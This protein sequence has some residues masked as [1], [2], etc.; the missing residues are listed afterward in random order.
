M[1]PLLLAP[2]PIVLHVSPKGSDANSGDDAHPLASLA[3][4]R[5]RIRA[6]RKTYDSP[7]SIH[8]EFAPGDYQ[9]AGT[10]TLTPQ[11]S[12]TPDAPIVYRAA[13]STVT[14]SGGTR[15]PAWTPTTYN[16]HAAWSVI[17][18]SGPIAAD[19]AAVLSSLWINGSRRTWARYP[20]AGAFAK[21]ESIPEKP[22]G[23]WLV[24]PK[25]FQFSPA[26][27]PAW[28]TVF[29]GASVTTFT[30]WIDT[31]L[32]V[33]SIDAEK[34]L[35][36]F[37][38]PNMIS[39][40]PTNL[41]LIEGAPALLDEPGEWWCDTSSRTVYT[42]PLPGESRD[43]PTYVPRLST[44]INIQGNLD[45]HETVHD[46]TFEGLTFAHAQWW[47]S[48]AETKAAAA[49]GKTPG[50]MQAAVGVPGA[51][52]A[53]GAER[54]AFNRCT[55]THVDSYALELARACTD[56]TI[57]ACTITDLGAGAIKIGETTIRTGSD[58]TQRNTVRDCFL[59]DGGH[60]HHQ[61]VG[62]W[63]GQ[64]PNNTLTHNSITEFDYT[65]IS[66]G[67]TWGYG[68]SAAGCNIVEF[69]RVANLGRRPGNAEPPL[70]DM[71]GIYTLG[72]QQGT[73]IKSNLFQDIFGHTIA[74]GIYFDEG[75]TG[76]LAE[77]NTVK[78]T[79][80]GSFHQHYGKDNIVRNNWLENARDAQLWRTRREDHN[81]FT[82]DH[83]IV[84]G[85]SD[86][87]L[88]GDWTANYNTNHNLYWR[89]SGKP[90]V[91]PGNMNL[92]QWQST[93][94]DQGSQI[95]DP[96]KPESLSALGITKPDTSTAG[97]R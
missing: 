40:E 91:F 7:T 8:V 58:L 13:P 80:H 51:I 71:G 21:I 49:K 82:F 27:A 74:W 11:D 54:I 33:A 62:V 66:I 32:T 78:N 36:R 10:F 18:P 85:D 26:D 45:S 70:G 25:S 83:N 17:V 97:P 4:A 2:P 41:Y 81:S 39:L 23:D 86:V 38:S 93:D 42:I 69:N 77:G 12:G 53:Q 87:W 14:F 92:L 89:P 29:P 64:S 84:I 34:R 90:I 56:C 48:Q 22:E 57:D 55:I 65:G 20:N 60:I 15:L 3:G 75:S 44:L 96:A 1:F 61:A 94:H 63:I 24:G 47:F 79:S 76:I 37:T 31:H 50:F 68:P 16:G 88:Q 52:V 43:S 5:D 19:A 95:A 30:R 72:T 9:L 6:L 67:W 46:I 59:S 28:S 35:V 73:I